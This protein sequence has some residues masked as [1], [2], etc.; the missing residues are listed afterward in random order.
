MERIIYVTDPES[1]QV[2]A[3]EIVHMYLNCNGS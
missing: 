3:N 1:F 2:S